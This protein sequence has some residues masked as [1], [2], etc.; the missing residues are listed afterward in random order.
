[1]VPPGAERLLWR[2]PLTATIADIEA[3]GHAARGAGER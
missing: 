2:R 3:P 1:M